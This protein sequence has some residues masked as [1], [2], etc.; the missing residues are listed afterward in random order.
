MVPALLQVVTVI[1]LLISMKVKSIIIAHFFVIVYALLLSQ[2]WS[3]TVELLPLFG[4]TIATYASLVLKGIPMRV[5]YLLP[6]FFW[7]IHNIIVQSTSGIILEI[8]VFIINSFTIVKLIKA[9]NLNTI[10]H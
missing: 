2:T 4:V 6:C 1:R 5:L 7:L 3:G 9:N 10:K 8:T